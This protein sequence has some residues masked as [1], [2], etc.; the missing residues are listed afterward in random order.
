ML[1]KGG[2]SQAAVGEHEEKN[3][4]RLVSR[5]AVAQEANDSWTKERG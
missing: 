4:R 2:R 5:S 3:R 1:E